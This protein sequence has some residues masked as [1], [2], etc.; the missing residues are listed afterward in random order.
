MA[1]YLQLTNRVLNELNEVE[2]TSSNFGSS[3][4]VQTMVKNVVN[5]S[6]HDI[7]NAEVEWSYLYKSKTQQL[8]AGKRLYAYPT[9]ARK[10]NFS[11]YMLTPVDLIT[12]G[13]FTNNLSDWTTV[14]GNPIHTKASGDG[15]V[16]LS[17]LSATATVNGATSSSTSVN[18]DGVDTDTTGTIATEQLVQGTG[19]S[20]SVTVSAVSGSGSTRAVTLSSSQTLA[21]NVDLTFVGAEI[22][23]AISTVVNKEYVVRTRTFGGDISLQIGTSSGGVEISDTTLSITNLGDGEYNIT[24]FTAT[25]ATTYISFYNS[26]SANYD[27]ETVEVTENFQPQ[28]LVYLSYN[29]WLD[30]H[31]AS[32]LST[33]LSSQFSLPRYV[34]RTQDNSYFGFS[35]IP[36]KSSYAVSFDYYKTHTDLSGYSDIPT[37]PVR[38]H[39]I[40][41]NRAKYYSY[42]MRA[43]MAGAQLAEKDY[44]EG[45]KRMRVELLNHQNYF[46]PSGISGNKNRLVGVTT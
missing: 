36:D 12:N 24:K 21:D 45:V 42:M 2:L 16:R 11:S 25:A 28:R 31:S 23:Q 32:D 46:Y 10:I 8:T 5:K 19:I 41:V 18:V 43:N 26:A 15:A 38:F 44:L 1:N 40:V 6:I 30:S 14:V 35:P 4:G 17:P 27:V 3:R 39:D 37:L 20:G 33:T 9:D 7:Y 34:Y 29:E 22:T 13:N